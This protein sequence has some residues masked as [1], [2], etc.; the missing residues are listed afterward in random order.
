MSLGEAAIFDYAFK[1]GARIMLAIV[2][3][4]EEQ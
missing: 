4:K 1:L 3:E 2:S